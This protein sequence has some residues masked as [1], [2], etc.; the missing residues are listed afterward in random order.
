[1]AN[2]A[3]GRQVRLTIAPPAPRGYTALTQQAIVIEGTDLRIQF[4]VKLDLSSKPNN[5]EV[6][7]TNLAPKTRALFSPAK[8]SR[9]WLHA[10]YPTTMCEIFSGDVRYFQAKHDGPNWECKFELGAGSRA[11]K[12]ARAA[13]AF[14]PGTAKGDALKRLVAKCGVDA[15]NAPDF[16]RAL[17]GQLAEGYSFE[18]PVQKALT[19]LLA[20][21]HLTW[22]VQ[23]GA[24]QI[25]P[26]KGY[27]MTPAILLTPSSGLIGSPEWGSPPEKG[28][29][30]SLK[31]KSLLQGQ[32]VPGGR[33]EIQ[34]DAVNGVFAIKEVQ[35]SGDTAGEDF[36]SELE[37]R[38]V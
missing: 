29:P 10:G 27:L 1:M 13:E 38:A 4:K 15:G 26:A 11:Y 23:R 30:R 35:H 20:P 8:G 37:L 19:E 14:G 24:L 18:G 22:S 25:L 5:S 6:T 12:H 28:G 3:W 7:V 33:V 31:A 36:C 21:E 17:T 9:L 32:F 16:Y 34:S 2:L